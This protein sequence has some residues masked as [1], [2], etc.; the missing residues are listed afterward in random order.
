MTVL[1]SYSDLVSEMGDWLN[2]ADLSAKIPTFVR[3]FEAR[4]NRRLRAP[5][6]EQTFTVDLIS[7]TTTYA[8]N[9]RIR[10]LREV[11]LSAPD[12]S[13]SEPTTYTLVGENIVLGDDPSDGQTLTYSGYAT[14][15]GLDDGNPANWLLND[16]P[17]LYLF[18][19]LARAEAYLKDDQRVAVWKA[20]EDEALAEVVREANEKRLPAGPLR[21]QPTVI[22]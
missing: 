20:A 2:R 11:Y 10:E 15:A 4:M 19:S 13:D 5:D 8:I 14:L 21:M 17:D 12:N 6:M 16:H 9:S 7:G 1:A 18:G 22:E 3:L